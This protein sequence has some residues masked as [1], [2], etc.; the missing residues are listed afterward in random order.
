[1]AAL[2]AC[3]E[4]RGARYTH[5]RRIDAQAVTAKKVKY[6]Q[7]LLASTF[8][9]DR[10]IDGSTP[11]FRNREHFHCEQLASNRIFR[12]RLRCDGVHRVVPD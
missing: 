2:A 11:P 8:R 6:R 3:L 12:P 7:L 1:M 4:P 5:A 10:G 9:T